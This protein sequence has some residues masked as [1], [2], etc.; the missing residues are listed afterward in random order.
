MHPNSKLSDAEHQA[1]M[2][3]LEEREQIR[4]DI[5]AL[6]F[7]IGAKQERRKALSPEM[8]ADKFEL[9]INTV[10]G[11]LKNHASLRG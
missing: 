3:L 5:L 6:R 9:S 1:L 11:Y 4:K 10:R 2:E 7:E 8:L